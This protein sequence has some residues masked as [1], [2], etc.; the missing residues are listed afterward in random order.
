VKAKA[1][2]EP[3]APALPVAV[4]PVLSWP[5]AKFR[6]VF[7]AAL[8]A[9]S[10]DE[11]RAHLSAVHVARTGGALTVTA[12]TG[13][14]LFRWTG[15]A[16]MGP[17]SPLIATDFA[18]LIPRKVVEL[19]VSSIRYPHEAEDVRLTKDGDRWR[20]DGSFGVVSY[21]FKAVEAEF[22]PV[23]SVFPTLANPSVHAIGVSAHILAACAKAFGLAT[24]ANDCG[25]YFQ[26]TGG[27][28]DAIACTSDTHKE[29]LAIV[30]PRQMDPDRCGIPKAAPAK[31]KAAAK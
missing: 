28:T 12:T 21:S 6:A 23:D 9:A 29:L 18:C 31:A 24:G 8:V 14:W 30:M 4:G 17:R 27:A 16:A 25:L 3:N 20:L 26:P 22:P 2:A 15:D 1:K 5:A 19:F 11:T 13:H 7:R 10:T